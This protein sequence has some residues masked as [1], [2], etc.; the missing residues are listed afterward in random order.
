MKKTIT[1]KILVID[2]EAS[3][4]NLLARYLPKL[5]FQALFA[6]DGIEG[7]ELAEKEVPELVITDLYMQRMD[8]FAV[9]KEM[10]H[11][12]PD[13]P[14]VVLSGANDMDAAIKA[15]RLGAWDYLRKPLEKLAILRNTL[16]KALER[17][18]LIKENRRYQ[19]H[20]ER[21]V[22]EK[23]AAIRA[24]ELRFRTMA[25]FA[26]DWECWL[27]PKGEVV[28]SSPSCERI[29]GYTA[30]EFQARP[31][32]MVDIVHTADRPMVVQHL[33]E[34]AARKESCHL[35][36]RIVTR[37]GAMRWISHNC[38]P[39][40]DGGGGF[41]GR[42]M[43]NR[44]I[45]RRKRYENDLELQ[46]QE[47]LQQSKHLER[48]NHAL[49]A[50]LDHRDIERQSI[51]ASMLANLKRH[52]F[53]YIEQLA[54]MR[55]SPKAHSFLQI[56]RTNIEELVTPMNPTLSTAYQSLTPVETTVA[57][58]IRLGKGTKEIASLQNV[59]PRTVA[60]HRNKIRKKLGLVNSKTNLQTYLQ[61]LS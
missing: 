32:L 50:M 46:Q 44:D 6:Q 17:A 20:L 26:H 58:L 57:D 36:F 22:S 28:Y 23:T 13:T 51:E 48:A 41:L 31:E 10:G 38:R 3:I 34:M 54:A 33:A 61:S 19:E 9:L 25:E 52:V 45:T 5:Q 60:I 30:S 43:S 7:L 4:R 12:H 27:S 35:E 2:D 18:H 21:M 40:H 1:P 29:T 49:K 55:L 16:T 11:L 56:I 14:V 24:G 53:P 42:R 37:D 8:G 47:L 59:S 15:L 39:V